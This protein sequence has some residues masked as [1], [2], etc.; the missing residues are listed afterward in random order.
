VRGANAIIELSVRFP[1]HAISKTTGCQ[2]SVNPRFKV[3]R[4]PANGRYHRDGLA[5]REHGCV[6]SGIG[7]GGRCCGPAVSRV[8][9]RHPEM[10][11]LPAIGPIGRSA[12][13][14]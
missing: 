11:I 2:A 8:R 10:L 5:S 7:S 9:H 3:S 4:T 1:S 13:T 6:Q 14:F 12:V